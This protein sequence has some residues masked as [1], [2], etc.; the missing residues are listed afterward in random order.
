MKNTTKKSLQLSLRVNVMMLLIIFTVTFFSGCDFENAVSLN[1][2]GEYP[3]GYLHVEL[4]YRTGISR[5]EMGALYAKK[6][7]ELYPDFEARNAFIFSLISPEQYSTLLERTLL[8]KDQIPLI[9][10]EEIDGIASQFSGGNID[11]QY[12]GVLSVNELYYL[13][14]TMDVGMFA[15]PQCSAL[16]VYG[17]RSETGNT[18][19]G[20]IVDFPFGYEQ[21]VF[22][23]KNGYHSSVS[24][25]GPLSMTHITNIS[26]KGIFGAILSSSTVTTFPDDAANIPYHSYSFDLR[27]AIEHLPTLQMVA[28]YMKQH[29]Y[30]INHLILLSDKKKAVVL[31]NNF[32][33]DGF[34][35]RREVRTENSKLHEGVVW[36]FDD[37]IAVVNSFLLAGNYNNHQIYDYN[38]NRFQEYKEQL[39]LMGDSVNL[40]EL[41]QIVTFY[42]G[43]K[44]E[45]GEIYSTLTQTIVLFDAKNY[46]LKVFPRNSTMD[47]TTGQQVPPPLVPEFYDVKIDFK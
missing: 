30:T 10:Q 28:M 3:T 17:K 29:N 22:V 7:I 39:A 25:G 15:S 16:A 34:N 14:L 37:A 11:S 6:L 9:Y 13:N 20:R 4:D 21:A 36:D 33:G 19:M 8:I 32:T 42:Q 43:D 5:Y 2:V 27:Y 35:M 47:F 31:E 41:Q 40:D 26:R 23:I 12:D 18:L 46:I 1:Y 38:V 24:I 45:Y 44:P